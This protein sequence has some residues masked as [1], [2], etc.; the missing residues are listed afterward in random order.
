[1]MNLAAVEDFPWKIFSTAFGCPQRG[2]CHDW[3]ARAG[4]RKFSE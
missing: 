2:A 4:W 1:M 3:I